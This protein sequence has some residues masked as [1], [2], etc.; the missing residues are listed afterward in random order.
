[1]PAAHA[2]VQPCNAPTVKK[3][4][5]FWLSSP[6][7]GVS[8]DR[9]RSW[10]EC[11]AARDP[12]KGARALSA[13]PAMHPHTSRGAT[14][15]HGAR[16]PVPVRA[17]VPCV[18]KRSRPPGAAA[19]FTSRSAPSPPLRL[20]RA[21]ADGVTGRKSESGAGRESTRPV[22]PATRLP[23]AVS[24]GA[25][26]GLVV[27]ACGVGVGQRGLVRGGQCARKDRGGGA[28]GWDGPDRNRAAGAT[29]PRRRSAALSSPGA[30]R[31]TPAP[32]GQVLPRLV[33]GRRSTRRSLPHR[34]PAKRLS[35]FGVWAG[36]FPVS[37]G[38]VQYRGL[39]RKQWTKRDW[40]GD[41][42][43]TPDT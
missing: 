27:G 41:R 43:G 5:S 22:R 12:A 20:R 13:P 9:D 29:L 6:A 17:P 2:T 21:A 31:R 33:A 42:S 25:Y 15:P 18:R 10:A 4:R 34:P 3:T 37:S 24:G 14:S 36:R 7:R 1:M 35:S 30:G 16:A 19:I 38:R 39:P 23:A 8:C 40:R 32:F 26:G 11:M 28:K